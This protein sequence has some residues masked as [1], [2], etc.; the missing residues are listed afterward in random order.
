MTEN[1]NIQDRVEFVGLEADRSVRAVADYNSQQVPKPSFLSFNVFWQI[2]EQC[3]LWRKPSEIA[4]NANPRIAGGVKVSLFLNLKTDPDLHCHLA[5]TIC[6]SQVDHGT[7]PWQASIRL[8]GP[9][10]R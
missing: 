1:Q 10:D 2:V 9:A 4:G 7:L 8:R 5:S 3:G 6:T